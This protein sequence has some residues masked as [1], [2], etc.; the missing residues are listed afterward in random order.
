MAAVWTAPAD[1]VTGE[2]IT[3]TVWNNMVGVNGND[4][5]LANTK[6]NKEVFYPCT[7]STATMSNYGAYLISS[8]DDGDIMG[9]VPAD[10]T[11]ITTAKV[12]VLPAASQASANWDVA[13]SYGAIG[14]AYNAH[15]GASSSAT[16]NVTANQ[17]FAIDIASLL[18]S[19]AAGDVFS[20][21]VTLSNS[22]HDLWVLGFQLTY[23]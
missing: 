3:A 2:L 18:G 15:T 9:M 17:L 11:S 4:Q 14:E 5:Y 12:I 16:Y 1:V 10:F 21:R 7:S 23:A 20:I 6:R 19:L 13:L 22:D 8:G